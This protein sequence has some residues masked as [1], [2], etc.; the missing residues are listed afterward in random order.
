M[1][2][3]VSVARECG[4]VD[5]SDHVILVSAFYPE[6]EQPQ[7][8]FV[9]T[10]D[11]DR[12]VEEVTGHAHLADHTHKGGVKIHIEEMDHRFHFALSGRSWGIIR[13]HFPDVLSKV[14]SDES[15]K[16]FV[17]VQLHFENSS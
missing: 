1:L 5:P 16:S 14:T 2:T 7:L 3:A 9:Y 12:A 11:R 13:Q 17:K 8:E 15:K 6:N 10:D 4:M